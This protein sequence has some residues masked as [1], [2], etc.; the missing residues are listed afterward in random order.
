VSVA[1]P[2]STDPVPAARSKAGRSPALSEQEQAVARR[3]SGGFG[4]PTVLLTFALLAAEVGVVALWAA[5]IVPIAVGFAINSWVSYAWYTVHH[6]ATHKAI[7]GRKPKLNWV[8]VACGNVAGFALQLDFGSYSTNH[9]KHHAHTNTAA[10]PDLAVKGPLWQMPIK[11]LVVTVFSVIGALPGGGRIVEAAMSKVLPPDAPPPTKR[12]LAARARMRRL[13]RVGLVV[14]VATIPLGW[15]WPAFLLLWLPSR[16]GIFALMVLF[17]WLPHFPFDRT[18]RFGATRIN[19]FPGSTWL[20]LQQDRHLIHH[21]YPTIPW[22]R[23]RAAF[24]E[25][26]PLLEANGAIIQGTGTSPH[27]PVLLRVPAAQ[28]P[29]GQD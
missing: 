7:S 24:R 15:F 13:T 14:L 18:D 21:L 29:A 11:W 19:R 8:E 1:E 26:R 10:D 20:L 22:Y 3:L 16:V 12:E 27:V 5:G 9:L 4:W 25:L 23:Y 17:Q 2:A 28:H 6:D